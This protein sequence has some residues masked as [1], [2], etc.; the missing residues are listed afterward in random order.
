MQAR[1]FVHI[2]R[3]KYEDEIFTVDLWIAAIE[4]FAQFQKMGVAQR[5]VLLQFDAMQLPLQK[6][7]LMPWS[8]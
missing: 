8:A 5:T 7:F 3:K 2:T 4:N 1:S 6:A